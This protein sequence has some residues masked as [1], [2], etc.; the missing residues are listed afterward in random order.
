MKSLLKNRNFMILWTGLSVSRFGYRFFNLAIMWFVMQE[1]GSP[2]ALGMT[3]L[4]FTI[5]SIIVEPIGGVLADKLNKKSIIVL[6]DFGNGIIM[7]IIGLMMINNYITLTVLLFLLV[8]T[9][10]LSSLFNPSANSSIPLLIDEEHL[11][12]ANSMNQFSTQ[13]SNIIGPALAGVF[14]AYIDNIGYLL[15][16]SSV[17][18]I[19][20]AITEI[21][22]HVP[23][24][25]NDDDVEGNGF[26]HNFIEGLKYVI[27]D[28]YLVFLIIVGGVI[29]N[30]FLAPLSIF[31]TFLSDNSFDVGSTGLGF[32][33][34]TLAVGALVG[35]II[36]FSN[37]IKDKY[38]MAILGLSLEGVALLL[39][40]F[41]FSYT[42]TLISVF[43]LGIGVCFAGVGINTLY[44]TMIP[45]DKLGRVLS[46]VS[47][48]LSTSVPLGQLFG[49][50]VIGKLS[51]SYVLILFGVIVTISALSLFKI[52]NKEE[53]S[54]INKQSVGL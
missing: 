29:I 36:I 51:T 11:S 19:I 40:G 10:I 35:T 1:T 39:M 42:G 37:L 52:T 17:A 33:N 9:S 46:L 13:C 31:F 47:M 34:S 8:C 15:I 12:K 2:L 5:P 54:G 45:R 16:I 6:T 14:I 22:L 7:C 20:S 43:I 30:F 44:Q 50:I 32:I 49:S 18:Y 27:S 48:L 21:W 24:I 3:V 4:C 26:I 41:I 23:S 53:Y 38:K 25:V 28:K